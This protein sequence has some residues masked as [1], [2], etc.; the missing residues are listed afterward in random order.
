MRSFG[1]VVAFVAVGMF[2]LGSQFALAEV[3]NGTFEKAGK[4]ERPVPKAGAKPNEAAKE[5]MVYVDVKVK[6][7]DGKDETVRIY[8]ISMKEQDGTVVPKSPVVRKILDDLAAGDKVRVEY[9]TKLEK[10]EKAEKAER[11]KYLRSI[12]KTEQKPK[13]DDK[14]PANKK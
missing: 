9:F 6:K 12:A 5:E 10:P 4:E 11:V 8:V 14:K 3:A 2:A 1:L 7:L 13:K